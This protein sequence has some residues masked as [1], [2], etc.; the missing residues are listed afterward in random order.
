VKY[1]VNRDSQGWVEQT[2]RR[3][4]YIELKLECTRNR[5]RDGQ[6]ARDDWLCVYCK[7]PFPSKLRLTDHMVGGCP[8][9]PVS[10]TG[11]K[12]ELPVYPNLKTAKQ[13][14]DLKAALQRGERSVWDVLQNNPMWL[15]LNPELKDASYPPAGARVH[16]R[17][18]M[19]P[20]IDGLKPSQTPKG[21][22]E[23]SRAKGAGEQSR[24][25]P[26]RSPM[27]QRADPSA[28]DFVDLGEDGTDD[29][30]PSMS[31]PKK[32]S[33]ERMEE[34]HRVF[35]SARQFKAVP[36]RQNPHSSQRSSRPEP[37]PPP[38]PIR[39]TP[40]QSRSP[41]PDRL[42]ILAPPSPPASVAPTPPV[43]PVTPMES[44][45]GDSDVASGLRKERQAFYVRVATSARNSVKMDIPKPALR[46]PIQPPGLYYLI[47]C[48]LLD[49]DLE[50]GE[51]G[52]FQEEVDAWK[53]DP[54]CMDR[55]FAAYGRFYRPSHQVKSLPAFQFRYIMCFTPSFGLS[56]YHYPFSLHA[57]YFRAFM[58]DN[59][60]TN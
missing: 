53:N 7:S 44:S 17:R 57:P 42:P 39:V 5:S 22:G 33:H 50:C 23:Q 41:S 11:E 27:R 1:F 60:A 15:E 46:P 32:R 3:R 10:P 30:E 59:V 35:T 54:A 31:R 25:R 38:H 51:F 28:A 55:L 16:V 9:G 45:R 2:V 24:A 12:L 20:T 49:F 4:V 8:C 19:H 26:P 21:A 36:K 29:V 58:L 37:G 56:S 52:A 43:T 47:P 18:F 14:K 13:G 48:G 34:G 40:I 6:K